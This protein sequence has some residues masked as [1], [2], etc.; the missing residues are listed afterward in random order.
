M[1]GIRPHGAVVH[2]RELAAAD[3]S[4]SHV[5]PPQPRVRVARGGVSGQRG[6]KKGRDGRGL[7]QTA[8]QLVPALDPARDQGDERQ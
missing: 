3:D 6:A 2:E 5:C 8:R 1:G 7:Q 4:G